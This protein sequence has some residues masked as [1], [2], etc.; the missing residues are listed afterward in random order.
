MRGSRGASRRGSRS[1]RPPP[2]PPLAR[3][4]A[5][6]SGGSGFPGEVCETGPERTVALEGNAQFLGSRVFATPGGSERILPLSP[7]Y[8]ASAYS[9]LRWRWR[10]GIRESTQAPRP[11]PRKSWICPRHPGRRPSIRRRAGHHGSARTPGSGQDNWVR[12]FCRQRPGRVRN[13]LTRGPSRRP[14][15]S[16]EVKL[17][18]ARH[19][20]PGHHPDR[21]R[22]SCHVGQRP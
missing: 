12:I 13:A 6:A 9:R 3:R 20:R 11:A 15:T 7:G 16:E 17:R 19:L 14:G 8:R 4:Y 1:S 18:I 22:R 2:G 10:L 5:H 21:R